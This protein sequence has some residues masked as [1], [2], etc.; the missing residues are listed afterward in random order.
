M[1]ESILMPASG[2]GGSCTALSETPASAGIDDVGGGD[3][4]GGE[5][6]GGLPDP[7]CWPGCGVPEPDGGGEPGGGGVVPGPG[8]AG[9]AG[10]GAA[11]GP[12]L[13]CPGCDAA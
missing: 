6:G 13:G 9:A 11:P 8:W 1:F 2:T 3:A 7:G 4:G 10:G 5:L 12:G